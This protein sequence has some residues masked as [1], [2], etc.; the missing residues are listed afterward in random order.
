MSE[1]EDD[2]DDGY[3]SGPYCHHW[4][5]P[6]DCTEPCATCGHTCAAHGGEWNEACR[7]T[8]CECVA[9]V[10]TPEPPSSGGE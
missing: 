4:S 6:A 2:V 1:K 10:E 8:D 3:E 5:D 9:F 7:K